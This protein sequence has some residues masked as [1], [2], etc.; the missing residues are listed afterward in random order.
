MPAA[1]DL[2]ASRT[3]RLFVSS[4][5]N[6]FTAEREALRRIVFPAIDDLCRSFGARFQAVDLRWGISADAGRDQQTLQ[7]C[8]AEIA[9]CQRITPRPNFLILLGDRYGWRPLPTRVPAAEFDAIRALR[10]DSASRELLGRF[11]ARDDNAL[12]AEYLLCAQPIG[13]DNDP[14]WHRGEEV[15]AEL[16]RNAVQE[17]HLNE[18]DRA[19][20]FASATEQEIIMGALAVADAAEHV[21][22]LRR[23]VQPDPTGDLSPF[24]IDRG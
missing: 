21:T 24:F 4:T 3:F 22:C 8:L 2:T 14:D 15:L 11:Y 23:V 16:L 9:R 19:K 12:P 10:T 20:Y 6:D 7:I 1:T 18:V 13:A 5:F 17:L